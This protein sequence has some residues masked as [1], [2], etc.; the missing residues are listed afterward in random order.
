VSFREWN[1]A[2]DTTSFSS[3]TTQLCWVFGSVVFTVVT[4][5]LYV[6]VKPGGDFLAGSLLAAWLGKSVSGV[7]SKQLKRTTDPD[8]QRAKNE[9]PGKVNV[10]NVE[11]VTVT[12]E[13]KSPAGPQPAARTTAGVDHSR[14]DDER[15]EG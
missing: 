2:L 13:P 7:V 3:L 5:Y 8:Y 15:G 6:S 1:N 4:A 9:A 11:N 12:E 10:E 14:T